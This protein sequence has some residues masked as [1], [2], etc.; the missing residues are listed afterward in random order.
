MQFTIAGYST[1]LFAT[2]YFIEELGL[3]FDAG[4]GV[5]AGLTQKSGK[6][7]HVFISH[8]DRDHVTGILQLNQLNARPGFPKIYYPKDSN[9]FPALQAFSNRFD[10]H[11]VHTEWHGIDPDTEVHINKEWV[12]KPI[13]NGHVSTAGELVKSLSYI[14][15]HVKHKL[16]PEYAGMPGAEIGRLRKQLGD[17]AVMQEVRE[18]VLAYSGDTPVE[19]VTR[20]KEVQI[21]IHEATFL[22]A[23]N[24]EHFNEKPNK[25]STLRE[26]ISM[27]SGLGLKCLILG[28]FSCRYNDAE[29]DTAIETLCAAYKIPFPVYRVLPSRLH[30]H[31]LAETPC[32]KGF[33]I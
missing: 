1:A 30:T 23:D 12:V 4:D 2:W 19:D 8:A 13:I 33:G 28:H 20:Y 5:I 7:K 21:L 18:A 22:E 16:R 27:A 15:Y 29:I 10:P 32:W 17:E 31:L 11:V 25:H 26:V 9:S 6:I 3:L 24:V 14:V